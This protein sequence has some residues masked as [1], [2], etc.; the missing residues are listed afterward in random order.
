[1]STDGSVVVGVSDSQNGQRAFRWTATAGMQSLG[2]IPGLYNSSATAVS[3]DGSVIVG[4]CD[5]FAFLWHDSAGMLSLQSYLTS[6]GVD[7]TGWSALTTANAISADGRFI[8]GNG[9]FEGANRSFIADIG[10]IPAPGALALL[11]LGG[12][13]RSRR[14]R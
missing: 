4:S 8:V 11:G 5:N 12:L 6:R 13:S 1:V 7:L 14:R 10:V 9:I 3:G 2:T